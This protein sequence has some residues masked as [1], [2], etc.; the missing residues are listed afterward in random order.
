MNIPLVV[1]GVAAAA[2]AAQLLLQKQAPAFAFL[3]S[4]AAALVLLAR[5]SSTVQTVVQGIVL[6]AN[7]ADGQAFSCLLRCTGILLLT[8]YAQTLCE[9]TGADS[10]GWCAGL[11]GRCLT[12]AAAFP[13]LEEVCNKIWELAG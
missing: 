5:V 10:L 11:A 13:L 8:D 7:R 4:L 12:L 1:L 2:A 3:L 6:L 9:E